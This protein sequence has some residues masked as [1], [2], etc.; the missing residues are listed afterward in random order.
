MVWLGVLLPSG[1]HCPVRS[2]STETP[3]L[4]SNIQTLLAAPAAGLC[5]IC[6][7]VRSKLLGMDCSGTC[8]SRYA[9][10][11]L[12]YSQFIQN[13][14]T[15]IPC[16]NH[17]RYIIMQ[18]M[19]YRSSTLTNGVVGSWKAER[20]KASHIRQSLTAASDLVVIRVIGSQSL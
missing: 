5:H 14:S 18:R 12:Q 8:E 7:V 4:H 2:L 13:C 15:H 16:K 6:T 1:S 3:S 9:T 17:P 11:K 19:K 20:V 10:A